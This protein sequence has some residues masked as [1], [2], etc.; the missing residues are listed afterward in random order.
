MRIFA[1]KEECS[2]DNIIDLFKSL[3]DLTRLRVLFVL[4]IQPHC[5]CE[6]TEIL[7]QPQ[8]K[9]SKHL[10]K[11]RDLGFVLTKRDAQFIYYE[12][13]KENLMIHQILNLLHENIHLYPMLTNDLNQSS[14]C[15]LV[16]KNE[17]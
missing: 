17:G 11:L 8:T 7:Q 5:V 1:Y 16:N 6:L 12:I 2:L 9:I 4:S 15:T 10:S 13:N 14:T 3:S